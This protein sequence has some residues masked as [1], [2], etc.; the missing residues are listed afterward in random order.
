MDLPAFVEIAMERVVLAFLGPHPVEL[1]ILE[2]AFIIEPSWKVLSMALGFVVEEGPFV[3]WAI[4]HDINSVALSLAF[5][6]LSHVDRPISFDDFAVA[7]GMVVL[8]RM[9]GTSSTEP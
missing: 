3:K 8:G 2:E 5:V 7:V 9:E 6:P 4:F 1:V